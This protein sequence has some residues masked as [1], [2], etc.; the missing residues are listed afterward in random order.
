LAEAVTLSL[1]G[2]VLG[3]CAAVGVIKVL[4][5]VVPAGSQPML[6]GSAFVVGFVFSVT[7]GVLAGVYPAY[8]AAKLD[9]IEALRYE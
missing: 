4:Q 9:P 7:A 5:T 1:L 2:G 8:K 3:I 6:V